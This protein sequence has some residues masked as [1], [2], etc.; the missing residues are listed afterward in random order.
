MAVTQASFTPEQLDEQLGTIKHVAL[1]VLR[2]MHEAH[3]AGLHYEPDGS[4]GPF[5]ADVV[6]HERVVKLMDS[7]PLRE[8]VDADQLTLRLTPALILTRRRCESMLTPTRPH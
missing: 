5:L 4:D 7:E 2:A 3:E 1:C 8:Y 6:Q